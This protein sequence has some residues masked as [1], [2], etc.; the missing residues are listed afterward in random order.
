MR[1][2]PKAWIRPLLLLLLTVGF[3]WIF[4]VGPGFSQTTWTIYYNAFSAFV[5]LMAVFLYTLAIKD[6]YTIRALNAGRFNPDVNR[7]W[8]SLWELYR[9]GFLF[10]HEK[11]TVMAVTY[12]N[13]DNLLS[14]SAERFPVLA[15]L[16]SMPGTYTGLGI[17]GTFIGFSAGL[18]NFDTANP[19]AI[20]KSIT[21]LLAGIETAF[22]TSIVGIVLSLIFNFLFLQPL[23][24]RLEQDC[25]DL[26]DR[27]DQEHYVDST[28][29]L[30]EI[31]AFEDEGR[32][33]L[34]RDYNQQMLKELKSQTVSLS[35]FTTDLSDTMQNLA[36]A[37]VASYRSEMNKMITEDL[38]PILIRLADAADKLQADKAESADQALQGIVTRLE[39]TLTDFM[40]DFRE[41]VTGQTKQEMERLVDQLK[42]AAE[43]IG[44]LP[45]L[46]E[47][48]K[49]G[50][51]KM[52][53]NSVKAMTEAAL[54]GSSLHA[55]N[56][57]ELKRLSEQV[58]TAMESFSRTVASA[59]TQNKHAEKIAASFEEVSE[60]ASVAVSDLRRSFTDF[61]SQNQNLASAIGKEAEG[62]RTAVASVQ[63]AAEGFRGLDEALAKNFSAIN[64]GLSEYREVT[65]DG[66]EK[67]LLSYSTS[68]GNYAG[69]LSGAVEQLG[70]LV[71]D[72]QA[73]LDS[74]KHS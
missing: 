15:I 66:L 41:N 67:H 2:S 7:K 45:S 6:S 63:S 29:H 47:D 74:R 33:W 70:A 73:A 69:R 25:A 10:R 56:I 43:S 5:L 54:Q 9:S 62:L 18:A 50:F 34:P 51:S 1:I 58:R 55:E 61:Q 60:A 57:A 40:H 30:K 68:I 19:E 35:N 17:L 39:Q 21:G 8:K 65:K 52:T 32:T 31:F 20:Q 12:F 72:L 36:E 26:S 11:T 59:D 53:E 27:L 23:L 38:Q 28:D 48:V 71:E 4:Y 49:G 24:K 3:V 16:K 13:P 22:N 37:L 44:A 14:A 46:L 42:A 64:A